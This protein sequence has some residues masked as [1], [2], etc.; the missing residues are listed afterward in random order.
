MPPMSS[1]TRA[2]HAPQ[3]DAHAADDARLN[4]VPRPDAHAREPPLS[5]P[6]HGRLVPQHGRASPLS[7]R[8]DEARPPRYVSPSRDVDMTSR[9]FIPIQT[10]AA[11]ALAAAAG[12]AGAWADDVLASADRRQPNSSHV[13]HGTPPLSPIID[14]SLALGPLRSASPGSTPLHG[15]RASQ[16]SGGG[17]RQGSVS[18][19]TW[20]EPLPLGYYASSGEAV[21]G[22][23]AAS[24]L[25]PD[26]RSASRSVPSGRWAA[27]A[28]VACA[29]VD[30]SECAR[31]SCSRL[32]RPVPLLRLPPR[33]R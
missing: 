8:P 15:R 20:R 11:L 3:S 10:S 14:A 7:G 33:I 32:S 2:A 27:R 13:R 18:P 21:G 23:S 6:T 30:A 31:V 17:S 22:I 24:D 1:P 5:S 25:K 9:P 28:R 26:D 16:A 12:A 29:R 4:R 19:P